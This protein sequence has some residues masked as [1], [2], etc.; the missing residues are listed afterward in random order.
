MR[1][2][3]EQPIDPPEDYHCEQCGRSFYTDLILQES[4]EPILCGE[5]ENFHG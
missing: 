4:D 2:F 5:C 3:P 1:D